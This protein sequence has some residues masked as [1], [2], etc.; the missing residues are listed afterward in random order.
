[1]RLLLTSGGLKNKVLRE[2]LLNL[3]QAKPDQITLVYV[4]TAANVEDE[5]KTWMIDNLVELKQLGVKKLDILDPNEH[6][7]NYVERLE[8]ANIIVFGGGDTEF[9]V[10]RMRDLQLA[11]KLTA[12]LDSKVFVGISAGSVMT[13]HVINPKMD[14]GF[15]WVDFLIV[16]HM[17]A[18]FVDRTQ[19]QIELYSRTTQRKVY[20]LDD[21]SA[22]R[23][24]EDSVTVVGT[25]EHM[26]V[27]L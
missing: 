3:A 10:R 6:V 27:E 15:A 23:V 7:G 19:E 12:W 18:P 2:E 22:V 24:K 21:D 26:V 13:G 4:S 16:P 1:M 8:A 25:G 9:L 17:N 11:N 20:W 14:A 5:D